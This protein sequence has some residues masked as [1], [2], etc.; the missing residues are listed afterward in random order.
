M[1]AQEN[2]IHSR[3]VYVLDKLFSL[4]G[5]DVVRNL[6][7]IFTHA[8]S[9]EIKA[10]EV[11]NSSQSPFRKYLVSVDK[12]KYFSF[13]SK[14]YFTEIKS[15]NKIYLE[16]QYKKVVK[17]FR[18]FFKYIFGLNIISLESTKKV[19]KDRL[20]IK[21]NI[22]NLISHLSE[23]MVKIKSS[24][25]NEN[26]LI[27]LKLELKEKEN[28]KIP[29]EEYEDT[30]IESE[31]IDEFKNCEEGWYVLYYN[32]CKKVCHKKCKGPKEGWNSTT[33]GCDMISTFG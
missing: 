5:N 22:I 33:Y 24:V 9:S 29:S 15:D 10:L 27:Q 8:S 13:D 30:I 17:N 21:N 28:S 1:K 23:T 6:I 16:E 14:I 20:H 4:F 19:I 2:R 18:E 31:V 32:I 26:T 7:I 3:L 12:Y 25:Y 11:V